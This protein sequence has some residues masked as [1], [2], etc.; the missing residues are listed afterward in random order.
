MS[1]SFR[2][3]AP[4]GI[5]VAGRRGKVFLR[6]PGQLCGSRFCGGK[7][8]PRVRVETPAP[9]G[10]V[11]SHWKGNA[12]GL[13]PA[14]FFPQKLL[15]AETHLSQEPTVNRVPLSDKFGRPI[16]DLRI[17]ITDHCNYKCVYCRTGN[18]GA[19]Y[20]DLPFADYLRMARI[21]VSLG[22]EK[23]RITGGE[24]LLRKGIVEFVR[25]LSRLRNSDG[26]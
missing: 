5:P 17:S 3:S 24:P 8:V 12:D 23:V 19:L 2:P 22:I 13:P 10:F 6:I 7:T 20:A 14:F 18:E 4:L 25:E 9:P 1:V 21:L 26:L 16:T 15:V 11:R